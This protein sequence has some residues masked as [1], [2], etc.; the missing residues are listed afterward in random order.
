MCKRHN[1]TC[2][3][4]SHK[5]P[6]VQTA[7]S[8]TAREAPQHFFFSQFRLSALYDR[9]LGYAGIVAGTRQQPDQYPLGWL[10][11]GDPVVLIYGEG[12][13]VSCLQRPLQVPGEGDRFC[14]RKEV[15]VCLRTTPVLSVAFGWTRERKH[16]RPRRGYG[17]G[18][19]CHATSVPG[20][21]S[22]TQL[23][24]PETNPRVPTNC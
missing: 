12:P 13:R 16:W 18:G 24:V 11:P 7:G 10:T 15:Q 17:T 20:I 2:T 3:G 14:T 19:S 21:R 4:P 22:S 9:T 1:N 5:G 6:S 8:L 23:G